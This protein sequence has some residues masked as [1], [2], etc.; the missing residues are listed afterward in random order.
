MPS[1]DEGEAAGVA[2]IPINTNIIHNFK[3]PNLVAIVFLIGYKAIAINMA[4]MG[5]KKGPNNIKGE[6]KLR[7]KLLTTL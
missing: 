1:K 6:S 4:L 2:I 7:I 5:C 3:K